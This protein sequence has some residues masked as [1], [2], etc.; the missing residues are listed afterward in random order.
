MADE[1]ETIVPE[2]VVMHADGYRRVN[3]AVLGITQAQ[4]SLH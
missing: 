2:A 1:V 3:Y 4:R